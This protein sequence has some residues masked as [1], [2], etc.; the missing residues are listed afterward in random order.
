[1]PSYESSNYRVGCEEQCVLTAEMQEGAKKKIQRERRAGLLF[2]FVLVALAKKVCLQGSRPIHCA[3]STV[4]FFTLWLGCRT[5]PPLITGRRKSHACTAFRGSSAERSELRS[6]I[7]FSLVNRS[8]IHSVG[9]T[10]NTLLRLRRRLSSSSLSA[11]T[12][13]SDSKRA[14]ASVRLPRLDSYGPARNM[15]SNPIR[16]NHHRVHN[17]QQCR[18]SGIEA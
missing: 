2:G 9:G 13:R 18:Q 7:S 10:C 8:S 17:Q 6:R 14:W 15:I 5:I 3:D 12:L 11:S 1:M 4:D 16:C